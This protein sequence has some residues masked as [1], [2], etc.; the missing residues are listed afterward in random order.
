MMMGK[1]AKPMMMKS[2]TGMPSMGSLNIAQFSSKSNLF[3]GLPF[4][5][6]RSIPTK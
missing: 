5:Y 4:A 1:M 3:A 2:P 6:K